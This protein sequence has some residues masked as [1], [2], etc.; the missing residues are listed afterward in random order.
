MIME[1]A[2]PELKPSRK[3]PNYKR[4]AATRDVNRFI[5]W[6]YINDLL[7]QTTRKMKDYAE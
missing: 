5:G 4:S 1:A 2:I 3:R 6:D 7:S